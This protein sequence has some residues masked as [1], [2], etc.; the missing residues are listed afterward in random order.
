MNRAWVPGRRVQISGDVAIVLTDG[1]PPFRI[2]LG[3]SE[4]SV[5]ALI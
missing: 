1:A 4:S 5:A 3:L 2:A